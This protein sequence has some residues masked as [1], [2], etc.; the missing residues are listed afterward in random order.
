MEVDSYV[1]H[2]MQDIEYLPELVQKP[3]DL[4]GAYL[5]VIYYKNLARI[6]M[7]YEQ[8]DYSKMDLFLQMLPQSL[9]V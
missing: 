7:F 1:K 4:Y 6:G 3:N 2:K 5:I 8:V 9:R